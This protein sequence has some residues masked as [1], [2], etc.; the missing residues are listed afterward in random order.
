[1]LLQYTVHHMKTPGA[2]PKLS[3]HVGGGD[4]IPPHP[5]G[6]VMRCWV[7]VAFQRSSNDQACL[8]RAG[9]VW[10]CR[11]NRPVVAAEL[12]LYRKSHQL[13]L[14]GVQS[15]CPGAKQASQAKL[16]RSFSY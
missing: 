7:Q 8:A 5:P 14:I 13:G 11:E 1:M 4:L 2:N 15:V 3:Y 12:S 6:S 16:G 9:L 10:R